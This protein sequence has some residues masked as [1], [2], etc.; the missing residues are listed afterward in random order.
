MK[1]SPL[2]RIVVTGAIFFLAAW[3]ITSGRPKV[4][5][6]TVVSAQ[7]PL[8]SPTARA[9]NVEGVVHIKVAT[10]GHRVVSAEIEDGHIL[11]ATGAEENARTWQFS[12]HEPTTFT[13][14]YTY[15]LLEDWKGDPDNPTVVLR[16]PTQVEI[17]T[18][19]WRTAD[20]PGPV[21]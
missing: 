5:L 1:H 14:T 15:R 16:L 17:S 4:A 18:S 12:L 19:H 9:A 3:P 11:L 8:Y 13:V 20:M 2:W 7:V 21:K 10:D 6:P